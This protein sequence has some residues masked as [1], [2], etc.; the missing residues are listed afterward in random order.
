MV[1]DNKGNNMNNTPHSIKKEKLRSLKCERDKSNNQVIKVGVIVTLVVLSFVLS[2]IGNIKYNR[3]HDLGENFGS[4][5]IESIKLYQF[6]GE[7]TKAPI[8]W[9]VEVSR[10][11]SPLMAFFIAGQAF[12]VL[13]R[14][15]CE[16]LFAQFYKKHVIVCGLGRKGSVLAQYYKSKG[17]KVIVIEKDKENPNI[18]VCRQKGIIPIFGNADESS[19]LLYA[20]VNQA[21]L[22]CITCGSDNMNARV[23]LVISEI[24]SS[25]RI[26]RLRIKTH[27][28]NPE[29][30]HY[31][32]SHFF[33]VITESKYLLDFYNIY[34]LSARKMISEF[35]LDNFNG[36]ESKSSH[37]KIVGFGNLAQQIVFNL[38]KEWSFSSDATKKKVSL[39]VIDPE[40][41]RKVELLNS[42][43]P[44]IANCIA[45]DLVDLSVEDPSFYQECL[46][47]PNSNSPVLLDFDDDD[48]NMNLGLVLQSKPEASDRTIII[49]LMA[50]NNLS[51]LFTGKHTDFTP[52]NLRVYH[53]LQEVCS[54]DIIDKGS[55]EELAKIIH[56]DY[57]R[58]EAEKGLSQNSQSR[59]MVPWTELPDDL[60]EMNREQAL[61]IFHK[62][63]LIGCDII[64]WYYPVSE[65]FEFTPDE[66]EYLARAEHERWCEQKTQQGWKYGPKRDE[67]K[68]IHPSLIAWDDSDFSETE[69][70]KDRGPIKMIPRYVQL[71]GFQIVRVLAKNKV[72]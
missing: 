29:Y 7:Y 56:E 4:I 60:K 25:K 70:D 45:F 69:K 17:Y 49:P 30:W 28:S 10:W 42:K 35:S 43:Y 62:L 33:T 46:K 32:K 61:A 31:I 47:S 2:I 3:I 37:L 44:R 66:I 71:A 58:Q 38:A 21:D 65:E 40:A 54:A 50:T 23:A 18:K 13:F 14:E 48:L 16:L 34:D 57:L 5:M 53:L 1:C 12:F 51:A 72:F 20:R 6:D 55:Y 63:Q 19:T 68:K 67:K 64:P 22:V 41:H 24:L 52:P 15:Q 9:E 11:L 39:S 8:P 26:E 59:A 36:F 27:I